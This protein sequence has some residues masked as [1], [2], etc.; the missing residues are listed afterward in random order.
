MAAQDQYLEEVF[1]EPPLISY[2]RQRNIRESI[3]RAKVT[4]E[5]KARELKGT[6]AL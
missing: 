3:I 2:K 1:P 6:R 4:P 5:R